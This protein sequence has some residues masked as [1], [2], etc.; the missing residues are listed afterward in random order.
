M[1]ENDFK[2]LLEESAAETHRRMDE[3]F[4]QV[5]A[6]FEQIDTRLEQIDVRLE[7]VDERFEQVDARAAG[8]KQHIDQI[9][10]QMKMDFG[11]AV[12][13]MRTDVQRVADGVLMVNAKLDREAA[14]IR[15]EMRQG[16][17][18]TQALLR[19]SHSQLADRVTALERA[20]K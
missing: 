6:R 15:A 5:D 1:D 12:E 7:K 8:L 13:A 11:L 2:R 19:F 3:R 9:A 18:D 20:A 14:D 17:A 4:D 16:F 10:V